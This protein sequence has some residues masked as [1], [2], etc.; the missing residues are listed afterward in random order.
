MRIVLSILF[1]ISNGLS[2]FGQS[3]INNKISF[4]VD[5]LSIEDAILSLSIQ[6]KVNIAFS[7][8]ILPQDKLI[9]LDVVDT[10]FKQVLRDILKETN[11]SFKVVSNQ[12]ILFREKTMLEESISI[13]GYIEDKSTGERLVGANIYNPNNA[14]GTDSNEFGYFSF[15]GV[16]NV[17]SIFIS[18]LGYETQKFMVNE[19]FSQDVVIKL[20]PSYFET[21]IVTA[22]DDA[23]EFLRRPTSGVDRLDLSNIQN[24]VGIGGEAD[25]FQAAYLLNGINT[26][27]DGVGGLHVRGGSLDQNLILLDGA[28]VYRPE[29][30][31][32]VLSIF[33]SD[34]ISSAKVYKSNFPVKYGSRL[35]SV[36]DVQTIEGNN[37][38]YEGKL[39]LGLLAGK[40]SIQGP[41]VK[42]AASFFVSYRRSFTDLYLPEI[43]RTIAKRD[44][45]DGFSNYFFYDLN[46]KTNF[47]IGKNDRFYLSY[48]EGKDDFENERERPV[49]RDSITLSSGEQLPGSFFDE[50]KE[51]LTWGNRVASL[52]WNHLFG[53]KIFLNT[54]A[55]LSQFN[56][57][58][59]EVFQ[60]EGVYDNGRTD[61]IFSER[62]FSSEV[63]DLGIRADAEYLHSNRFNFKFGLGLIQHELSPGSTQDGVSFIDLASFIADTL[64]LSITDTLEI[65]SLDALEGFSYFETGVSLNRQLY[66][67]LGVHARY[68]DFQDFQ[69]FTFLPRINLD[70]KLNDYFSASAS[71]LDIVQHMHLLT[72]SDIG[73]PGD[74]WVPSS[75]RV[76][77]ETAR[78]LGFGIQVNLP[79]DITLT[80]DIYHKNF[81]NLVEFLE[82]DS[83]NILDA[84]NY[85]S[86]VTQGKGS[87]RGLEVGLQK[88][89]ER[90][91]GKINYTWSETDRQFDDLN[92]GEA[93]PYRYDLTHVANI[94][95]IY[96]F[97][98]HWSANMTWIYSSGINLTIPTSKYGVPS[99]F[100]NVPPIPIPILSSRNGQR[101][102][103]NHRLDLGVNYKFE[104]GGF[105]HS[106]QIGVYN[107]YNNLNPI[108]YRL[109]RNPINRSQLQF[110]SVSL[111]PITP[112]INY[113]IGF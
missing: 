40:A 76:R 22:S 1:I 36:L 53:D 105:K 26:G 45:V 63:R 97:N 77:P 59:S 31:I 69:D 71:Y 19:S 35:S 107:V 68:W 29:H 28:P 61:L 39:S 67:T 41:I 11:I 57:N 111:L 18:Y 42:N 88:V 43:T 90:F 64:N 81:N 74:I 51:S 83:T 104:K 7:N 101:L 14:Y 62:K 100:P 102:P 95:G 50:N 30:A 2:C 9:S 17:D 80:A 34:A 87:S 58:S 85:E 110:V 12:I 33:N 4:A 94:G 108:Y 106:L 3:P 99:P 113:S 46:V 78:H 13:S 103:A 109:R 72:K 84:L 10:P 24:V 60:S 91:T 96:T 16:P 6:S 65:R 25:L 86:K 49:F 54:T 8:S 37:Q 73:L 89:G 75:A 20:V 55:Y 79:K 15:N 48:Y 112:S 52:R 38:R 47:R 92:G 82:G 66:L 98:Q 70:Y 56:F 21:I 93:F 23:E 32:G 44:S 5:N 27:A